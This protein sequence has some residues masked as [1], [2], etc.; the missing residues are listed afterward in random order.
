MPPSYA[1]AHLH[2]ITSVL[3]FFLFYAEEPH[4]QYKSVIFGNKM[5]FKITSGFFWLSLNL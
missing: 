5:E 3:R 2:K 4:S 1:S